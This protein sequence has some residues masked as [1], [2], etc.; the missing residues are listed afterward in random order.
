MAALRV[1]AFPR[2]QYCVQF[3]LACRTYT[4]VGRRCCNCL[5]SGRLGRAERANASG[6]RRRREPTTRVAYWNSGRFRY[7]CIAGCSGHLSPKPPASNNGSGICRVLQHR[8]SVSITE[9]DPAS[10]WCFSPYLAARGLTSAAVRRRG[11][12]GCHFGLSSVCGRRVS[13]P[14]SDMMVTLSRVPGE[15]TCNIGKDRDH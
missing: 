2:T 5:C 7:L 4:A 10:W 1:P 11:V 14:L 15:A 6:K 8:Y 9:R 13:R 12:T 3:R